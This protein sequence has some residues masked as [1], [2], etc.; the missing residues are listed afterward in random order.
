LSAALSELPGVFPPK[1]PPDRESV[2]HKYRVRLD[3][4]AAGLS[5]SKQLLRKCAERALRA[6]GL[7]VVQWETR[8]LVAYSLFANRNADSLRR[9]DPRRLAE[10]YTIGAYPVTVDLL[11]SSLV[12]FSQSYPLIAQTRSLVDRY[13]EAF[14]KV[15][16]NRNHWMEAE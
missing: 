9:A 12:L 15:W 10:N 11:E 2:F 5:T 3:P 1:E 13:A 4:S 6:E 8:P 7:E 14:R 16:R